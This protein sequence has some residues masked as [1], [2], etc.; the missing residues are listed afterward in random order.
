MA[1]APQAPGRGS[2]R[3]TRPLVVKTSLNNPYIIRWS[4]LESEDMHFILQTLEDRLKAIG[5]QKIEDKKK[6]N[7]TPFLKKESREKCSIAVDISENLKEKKTDAKQ[8]VS[9]WTPAHVRKQLAI[10]V[11]EVTRALERRELLLVLVCK[12][13]KPAMITSHLIQLSL[14]R[15]VPACQVPRLSE[16]IAPVIGLKCVLALAFKKNTTDFVDEVRAIIPRVP[17][18]S[19]PWLQDRIEDSGE[20]L[21]TEPL[22]S[23]D[24]E[25][26]DTSFEDLSKPKRKLADGRQASV[27]LQPLKIKKLIPNPNKIRKPPK[28]KKAT[29]K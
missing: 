1:A 20:N 9:G 5:L 11:N 22:E 27:T 2:L 3:K 8:Q 17:S 16:R 13:V 24:R 15:S 14:S 23:Q 21:E 28:S 4:A 7:K 29:P 25:L 26:L 6:K 18:L 10:G 12:S 19:V